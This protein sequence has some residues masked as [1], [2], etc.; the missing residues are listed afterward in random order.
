MAIELP[1]NISIKGFQLSSDQLDKLNKQV[2]GLGKTSVDGAS[3]GASAH[4]KQT[5]AV[6]KLTHGFDMSRA[7]CESLVGAFGAMALMGGAIDFLKNAEAV[8]QKVN[9][10][11]TLLTIQLGHFS[12]ALLD[13]ADVL[14]KTLYIDKQ[15]I[16]QAD[17]RML[18]YTREESSIKK[19]IPG[20]ID[21]AK[22][23][24]VDL[25]TAANAVGVSLKKADEVGAGHIGTIRGM[26]ITYKTMATEAQNVAEIEKKLQEA[27]GGSAQ[28]VADSL[29]GWAKFAFWV[30]VVTEKAGKG[31]FG[32]AGAEKEMETYKDALE[33]IQ[34]EEAEGLRRGSRSYKTQLDIDYDIVDKHN[35]DMAALQAKADAAAAGAKAEVVQET[36]DKL[37]KEIASSTLDGQKKL[38]REEAKEEIAAGADKV[39]VA[40]ATA[41]KIAKID[42]EIANQNKK[43]GK[44]APD[45]QAE[46]RA[47]V[48]AEAA[49]RA[50]QVGLTE[51][52]KELAT[53]KD[54]Y[55]AD[56]A[57]VGDNE[58]A[59]TD[60]ARIYTEERENIQ[61]KNYK[62]LET[63][64]K[65]HK[66]ALEIAQAASDRVGATKE[67]KKYKTK[68]AKLKHEYE[69]EKKLLEAQGVSTVDL[70]TNYTDDEADVT[71]EANEA[72][73]KYQEE[74]ATQTMNQAATLI[75]GMK[76]A[77]GAKKAIAIAEAGVDAGKGIMGVVGNSDE[78][79]ANFGPV[80]GPIAEGVEIALI[81]GIFAEQLANI[82]AQKMAAGGVVS[83]GVPGRD[84]VP[85]LLMPGEI[86][87]NPARP[88]PTLANMITASQGGHTTH[89]NTGDIHIHGNADGRTV[90]AVQKATERGVLIA[91]KK[92]QQSGKVT[93]TG[94]KI[95]G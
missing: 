62:T 71:K 37:D 94:L 27:V 57:L 73:T 16:L 72:K 39:L 69:Q 44:A 3:A 38:I 4:E 8:N 23:K 76:G 67:D 55:D 91:L 31:I 53:L 41:I 7:A 6:S 61:R 83:G 46:E 54:K 10:S 63:E 89:I 12:D 92:M 87:Y 95:R 45:K 77:A 11:T 50:A 56:L 20:I 47:K 70:T 88:D 58:K 80:G 19:L 14:S 49:K 25:V 85:A 42:E 43:G 60:L 93:A 24:G 34:Q 13:Q 48:I 30:G 22:L 81:T 15:E 75:N 29:G 40:K 9:T 90:A 17:Q 5:E 21:L 84:S 2:A 78:Y 52:Q 64:D 86:V 36:N 59:K 82:S 26:G 1:V 51:N 35:K 32:A 66:K 33:D 18:V 68:L 79:I 65:D 74:Y 28:A